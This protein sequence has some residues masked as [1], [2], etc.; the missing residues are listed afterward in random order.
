[1][2]TVPLNAVT[3]AMA[4]LDSYESHKR[5]FLLDLGNIRHRIELYKYVASQ[6]IAEPGKLL[7]GGDMDISRS[8]HNMYLA[9]LVNT[10]LFGL[11]SYILF[12]VLL[13]RSFWIHKDSSTLLHY[14][15]FPIIAIYIYCLAQNQEFLAP[16]MFLLLGG[17]F[18]EIDNIDS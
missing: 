5:S 14:Y 17:Y 3:Y 12:M 7:L 15:I 1:M 10:G 18:R 16:I 6:F 4:S 8:P 11:L 9:L 2:V 13:F